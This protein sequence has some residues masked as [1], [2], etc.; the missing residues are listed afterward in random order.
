MKVAKQ[1]YDNR[2]LRQV[3]EWWVRLTPALSG[4]D[5]PEDW[6]QKHQMRVKM[7]IFFRQL[8]EDVLLEWRHIAYTRQ[9]VKRR[10]K[11]ITKEW[12]RVVWLEFRDTCMLNQR[13]RRQV[14][15]R[16]RLV[17]R[18]KYLVPFRAWHVWTVESN[19]W[20][21]A[22]NVYTNQGDR[23]RA[24]R[25]YRT[26]FGAWKDSVFKSAQED[27]NKLLETIREL[28]ASNEELKLENERAVEQAEHAVTVGES[29]LVEKER[30]AEEAEKEAQA[31]A[32]ELQAT[33]EELLKVKQAHEQAEAL[34]AARAQI[35]SEKKPPEPEPEPEPEP[36][37]PPKKDGTT[38][39]ITF[40]E[41]KLLNRA[42]WAIDEFNKNPGAAIAQPALCCQADDLVV[43]CAAAEYTPPDVD[44][45][46]ADAELRRVNTIVEML[47]EGKR[48]VK[49]HPPP[50]KLAPV[51][52]PSREHPEPEQ[53]VQWDEFLTGAVPS[54][55]PHLRNAGPAPLQTGG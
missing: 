17:T 55:S 47:I 49:N 10:A 46:D 9:E 4:E 53:D 48:Q 28:Q 30:R 51:K 45:T 41:Q 14:V 31:L 16:M 40:A 38:I 8:Q 6:V 36:P 52:P 29:A 23:F 27:S 19:I 11:K 26:H 25:I 20:K 32:L 24:T 34:A 5:N 1:H 22:V 18:N 13:H 54:L 44:G 15:E 3:I 21:E 37:P 42:M 7:R 35:S 2:W 39:E 12:L 33:K 50:V 43:C